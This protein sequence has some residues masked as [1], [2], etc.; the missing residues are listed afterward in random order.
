MMMNIGREIVASFAD[1]IFPQS[2]AVCQVMSR[3]DETGLC[4]MCRGIVD[5]ERGVPACPR[6]GGAVALFELHDG[7]CAKCR[8]EP[9]HH[10]FGSVRVAPYGGRVGAMVRAYKYQRRYDLEPIL[11][12]W[13][14]V[15]VKGA[16]WID[17]VEAIVS[18]PTHWRSR[19]LRPPHAADTLAGCVARELGLPH[20]QILYRT[21]PGPRQVG[22]SHSQRIVN[23]RGAFA[24]RRGVV[25]KEAR[26]L[27]ID[28]VKTTGATI[29]E[30]AK[31]L[32]K[33]GASEVY[34]ATVAKAEY[35]KRADPPPG[36]PRP[37]R[38]YPG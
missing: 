22:L 8:L 26:L 27:I 11:G 16:P 9:R 12:G 24:L 3:T 6:C 38:M 14:A 35:P 5:Q 28:D 10:V 25:L 2:C 18:V 21:R 30:C 32:N 1:V 31:V 15:V 17:R 19:L 20:L 33:S 7:K 23:V 29:E 37:R 4:P 34:A 36:V 13:L